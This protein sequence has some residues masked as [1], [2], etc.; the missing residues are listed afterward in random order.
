M[1]NKTSKILEKVDGDQGYYDELKLSSDDISKLK[2]IVHDHFSSQ[3][4]SKYPQA[5]AKIKNTKMNKYHSLLSEFPQIDHSFLG[6]KKRRIL[7]DVLTK[8]FRGLDFFKSLED[9]LGPI[10]ITNEE[11]LYN[12]EVYWRLTRPGHN[13]VGPMHA[14]K[15]FW[16]LGHGKT[17][18]KYRRLKIWIS[19]YNETGLN[20]LRYVHGSHLK[21]WPYHGEKRD[22]FVKP[23]IDITDE[24]L[25]ITKFL[26]SS[27]DAFIFNDKLLHGGFSGGNESR[28]SI[29]CT[30]L[31]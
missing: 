14:D 5:S 11:G 1:T 7:P 19:I 31:I 10:K 20:G 3:L 30:M 16:D 22:G 2:E 21:D 9:V 8:K 26:S 15:W 18:A 29:E 13:D 17:S 27:G 24:E 28:V 12:E 4:V 23:M 6:A 25:N